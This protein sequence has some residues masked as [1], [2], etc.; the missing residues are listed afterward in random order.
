MER[1]DS[2]A[3]LMKQLENRETNFYENSHLSVW[4]KL[5]IRFQF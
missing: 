3:R 1:I 2:E 4:R 5:A